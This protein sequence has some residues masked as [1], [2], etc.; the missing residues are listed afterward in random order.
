MAHPLAVL[1]YQPLQFQQC[2]TNPYQWQKHILAT[3]CHSWF[4]NRHD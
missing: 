4:L 3:T 1:E 2:K